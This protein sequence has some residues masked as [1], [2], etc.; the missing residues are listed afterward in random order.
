MAN[1]LNSCQFI[2]RLGKDPEIKFMPSGD[3]VANFSVACGESAS[4][5][6][7]KCVICFIQ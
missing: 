3:A 4:P 2:G 5:S 1:D 7:A 6:S